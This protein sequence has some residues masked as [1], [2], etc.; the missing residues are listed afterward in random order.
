MKILIK[1]KFLI[2]LLLLSSIVFGQRE[3]E[4]WTFG[5]NKWT[6]NNITGN[7]TSSTFS[8]PPT[9]V[10]AR[11]QG[12]STISDPTTG[13]LLFFSDGFNIYNKNYQLM[14]DGDKMY[15]QSS[16]EYG[17]M[18]SGIIS[19]KG[20]TTIQPAVIV[21]H[22]GNQNLYYVFFNGNYDQ[23][24]W[25]TTQDGGE[26]SNGYDVINMGLRVGIVDLTYNG[27]LGKLVIP[28]LGN[29]N[30]LLEDVLHGLTTARHGDGESFWL[31]AQR[32]IRDDYK[33][34]TYEITSSG[35]QTTPIISDA[36]SSSTVIK[37]SPNG[38]Y[39]FSGNAE[40]G[41]GNILYNFDNQSGLVSSPNKFTETET[42]DYYTGVST[43]YAEFSPDSNILYLVV[44]MKCLCN[45]P[46]PKYGQI[47]LAMY[48]IQTDELV[49]REINGEAKFPLDFSASLQLATNEKIYLTFSHFFSGNSY[50]QN[51]IKI[52]KTWATIDS[53]NVWNPIL[54]PVSSYFSYPYNDD[55]YMSFTF[56]Q[57]IPQAPECIENLNITTP[58]SSNQDFQV[59]NK[60]TA[61]S[62]I[63]SNV[64]VNF[65]ANEIELILG[66]SVNAYQGS[67]FTAI[68]DPCVANLMFG[69]YKNEE[70]VSS[71]KMDLSKY[72][73][74]YP[75]P[76]S[77]NLIVDNIE[78]ILNWRLV[79]INGNI[80]NVNYY[81]EKNK[82]IINLK[83]LTKG[84]YYFNGIMKDDKRFQETVMKM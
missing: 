84:I 40:I 15:D 26:L 53:P 7:L 37:V 69:K 20:L 43:S 52:T 76:V 41:N 59:S 49:G 5:Y 45:Y 23:K 62:Q 67:N 30:L 79:D 64:T 51:I 48:N 12:S 63:N 13:E 56:P 3:N 38:K 73:V 35:L 60:I 27:G 31:I 75:N 65:K 80:K 29:D 22:P 14:E 36:E 18:I 74:I 54:N 57:L 61:S 6:F 28:N 17:V 8:P 42:A 9:G 25:Y 71:N 19:G 32:K 66:F 21:P 47:G 33:F 77:T 55:R 11:F 46:S 44:G 58:I 68:I 16:Y 81:T 24:T 70:V 39:L 10:M 4:N 72:P 78:H 2:L 1:I 83:N 50:S 34:Y 82:I